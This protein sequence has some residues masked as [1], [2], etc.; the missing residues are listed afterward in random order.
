MIGRCLSPAGPTLPI[1][2]DCPRHNVTSPFEALY[3]V[4]APGLLELCSSARLCSGL[5]GGWTGLDCLARGT[6]T[7]AWRLIYT[8]VLHVDCVEGVRGAAQGSGIRDVGGGGGGCVQ[9]VL[10]L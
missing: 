9:R 10:W 7:E 5:D 6:P 8:A 1:A 3:T 2:N 4:R